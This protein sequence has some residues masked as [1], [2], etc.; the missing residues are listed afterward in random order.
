M[1]LIVNPSAWGN[2]SLQHSITD[3]EEVC[4]AMMAQHNVF[5]GRSAVPCWVYRVYRP[6]ASAEGQSC[7][8]ILASKKV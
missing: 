8:L 5:A 4:T 6:A 2:V 1:P 7:L 3:K